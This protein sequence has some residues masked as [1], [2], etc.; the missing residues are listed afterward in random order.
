MTHRAAAGSSVLKNR[1]S[2]LYLR[3]PLGARFAASKKMGLESRL[4]PGGGR[5]L[6]HLCLVSCPQRRGGGVMATR[7]RRT[8]P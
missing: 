5:D 1:S 3:R 2:E 6:S 4:Q 7:G 8:P